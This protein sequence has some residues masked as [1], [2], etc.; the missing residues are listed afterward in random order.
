MIFDRMTLS[1]KA[2]E[3]GFNRSEYEK[4][5]RL[6]DV[7][8][9]FESDPLLSS[10]LA[11]K[12]GTALNL[13]VFDVPRLSVDIDL[14]F[15]ENVSKEEM[16]E[17]RKIITTRIVKYMQANGYALSD[18]SKSPHALDSFV[19]NY[20]NAVEMNDNI[21]IE[22]N[23]M[24][25]CHILPCERRTVA[26]GFADEAVTVLC[27]NPIE[28]YGSKI[29]ALINR[30]TPR[31]LFDVKN[32][33]ERA[34]IKNGDRDILRKIVAFYTALSAE[35]VSENPDFS[36]IES[37][38]QLSIKK[39]LLPVLKENYFDAAEAKSACITFLNGILDFTADE[40]AFLSEFAGGNFLP[41][42]L[43]GDSEEYARIK[44][45]PMAVFKCRNNSQKPFV[46]AKL[47]ENKKKI[48]END[49]N[50]KSPAR[51]NHER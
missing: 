39:E 44:N 6:V 17:R 12:G 25:R 4:V 46:L 23:Y 37:I 1:R 42:L 3:L 27:V 9:Y 30:S 24:N 18:K 14:D 45:H 28:I 2:K 21:K 48:Q 51:N 29:T 19:F 10:V 22:I 33:S 11:L 32:I 26:A 35:N 40:K 8:R 43:F 31:D 47:E 38:T 34:T 7:L 20:R 16:I 13:T 15:T 49:T 36:N 5:C 50:K 41:D